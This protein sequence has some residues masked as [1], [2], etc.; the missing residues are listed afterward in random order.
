MY[1]ID[2]SLK[3]LPMCTIVD[4]CI[5]SKKTSF[6]AAGPVIESTS[7]YFETAAHSFLATSNCKRLGF[8]GRPCSIKLEVKKLILGIAKK[9]L[10]Q[11]LSES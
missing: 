7:K 2:Y 6:V 8:H 5:S 9:Y 1:K 4:F 11:Y 3:D 10:K